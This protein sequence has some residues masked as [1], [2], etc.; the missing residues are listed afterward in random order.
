MA[1]IDHII[2]GVANLDDGIR[3]FEAATGVSPVRGGKH[4]SRGT[5]NALVSL[6]DMTYLEIIA[7]QLDAPAS[8]DFAGYLRTLRA[9]A[10]I[11]WAVRAT[12]LD[13][14][15]TRIQELGF[16]ASEPKPGSRITPAG[17][18]LEWV[19]FEVEQTQIATAPF[20][21][22][23]SSSTTHPSLSSPGGCTVRSFELA[24]PQSQELSRLLAA[25]HVDVVVRAAERPSMDLALQ[26]AGRQASF[27]SQ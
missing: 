6:G 4:P 15:R 5:E 19:T 3:A 10:V 26:C 27:A 1:A 24:D 22:Q 18:T 21:I 9:P 20:F 2:I 25:L 8:D 11:G 7:P 14:V 23:W 16:T 17:Q 13:G 12:D